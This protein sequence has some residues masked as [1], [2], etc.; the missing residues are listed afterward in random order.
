MCVPCF[1][2][3]LVQCPLHALKI[4]TCSANQSLANVFKIV[5]HLQ[6]SS[7]MSCKCFASSSRMTREISMFF[8]SEGIS[9]DQ[10]FCLWMLFF[11]T[12]YLTVSCASKYEFSWFLNLSFQ[13][14]KITK[15]SSLCKGTGTMRVQ[16][17]IVIS[18]VLESLL[19]HMVLRT[20]HKN[21]RFP[22]TYVVGM[23]I[24]G[25]DRGKIVHFEGQ[26]YHNAFKAGTRDL[27]RRIFWYLSS[28][29][30]K[31]W[32]HGPL[33]ICPTEMWNL[34]ILHCFPLC[35]GPTNRYILSTE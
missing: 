16:Y 18:R 13:T 32:S 3:L 27:F 11:L 29:W 15:T 8:F 10:K 14:D 23:W 17:F 19:F 7:N 5:F 9:V 33:N 6:I 2:L 34:F 26:F 21:F 28:L 22:K 25:M 24:V 35:Q 12:A 30:K 20:Q 1:F 4:I 31:T